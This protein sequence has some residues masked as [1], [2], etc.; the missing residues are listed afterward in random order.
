LKHKRKL[1]R[2]WQETRDPA[3]KTAVN[4]VTRSI[5]KRALERWETNLAN[6]EVTPREIW[7]IENFLTKRGAPKVPSAIRGALGSIFCPI[8][9]AKLISKCPENQ[10]RAHDL[11]DGYRRLHVEAEV[12]ALLATVGEDIPVNPQLCDVSK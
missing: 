8:G 10:F 12:E 2:L 9:D 7:P 6:C 5:R 1:R 4:Y 3:C 11:C